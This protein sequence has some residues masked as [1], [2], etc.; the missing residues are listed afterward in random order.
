LNAKGIIP[1]VAVLEKGQPRLNAF[2]EKRRFDTS[3]SIV[4]NIPVE[5]EEVEDLD[6]SKLRDMEG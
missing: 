4:A 6:K 2:R 3:G 5:E 1:A